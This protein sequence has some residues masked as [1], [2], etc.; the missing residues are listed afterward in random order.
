MTNFYL[1]NSEIIDV[2]FTN[3]TADIPYLI[4]TKLPL[5]LTT[6]DTEIDATDQNGIEIAFRATNFKQAQA[7]F[8]VGESKMQFIMKYAPV[9]DS[10]YF[11]YIGNNYTINQQPTVES[12]QISEDLYKIQITATYSQLD[13]DYF[14]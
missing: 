11:S 7:V 12:E 6:T 1:S 2:E 10:S 14:K 8:F 9:C 4:E 13:Y 5:I 3:E